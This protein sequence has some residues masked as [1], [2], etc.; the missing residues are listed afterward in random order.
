MHHFLLSRFAVWPCVAAP[1]S[2]PPTACLFLFTLSLCLDILI[3]EEM[4]SAMVCV[5]LQD[6]H[7]SLRQLQA[8][9]QAAAREDS[10]LEEHLHY[11][12][13]HSN[14]WAPVKLT[15]LQLYWRDFCWL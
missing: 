3:L 6:G 7:V 10:S 4:R 12:Q 15:V 11:L 9:L 8:L 2:E 1:A 5:A 14:R 13:A